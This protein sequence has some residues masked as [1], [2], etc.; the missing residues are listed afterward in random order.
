L[1]HRGR[2]GEKADSSGQRAFGALPVL[3][4]PVLAWDGQGT[5]NRT[6]LCLEGFLLLRGRSDGEELG[7]VGLDGVEEGVQ[8]V[9]ARGRKF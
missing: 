8:V 6:L 5:G 9:S 1:E 4:M 7:L 3:G 2:R